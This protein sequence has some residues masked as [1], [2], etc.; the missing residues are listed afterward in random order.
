MYTYRLHFTSTPSKTD[1]LLIFYHSNILQSN[2]MCQRK[3]ERIISS[4][5]GKIRFVSIVLKSI[6]CE[7]F[8][9]RY[10]IQYKRNILCANSNAKH[11]KSLNLRQQIR[12]FQKVCD[13]KKSMNIS[14]LFSKTSNLLM[15]KLFLMLHRFVFSK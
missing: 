2:N 14:F 3:S 1:S 12:N 7:S 15:S 4:T 11:N 9:Q 8:Q 13:L 5:D 6:D 10:G